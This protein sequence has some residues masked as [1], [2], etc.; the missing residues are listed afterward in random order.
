MILRLLADRV[1][2]IV[3]PPLS[4]HSSSATRMDV[5]RTRSGRRVRLLSRK[6]ATSA[7]RYRRRVFRWLPRIPDDAI[8]AAHAARHF[9]LAEVRDKPQSR[10]LPTEGPNPHARRYRPNSEPPWRA[11]EEPGRPAIP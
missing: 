10:H 4:T 11:S 2:D 1:A 8:L 5:R 3:G 7:Q 6:R 9:Q